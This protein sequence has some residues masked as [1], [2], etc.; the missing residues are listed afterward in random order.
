MPQLTLFDTSGTLLADDGRGRIA[1]T[2]RLVD[3]ATADTWFS[4]LR[5]GA[6]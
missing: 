6:G 5:S 4:E 1:Y 3:A 2:A